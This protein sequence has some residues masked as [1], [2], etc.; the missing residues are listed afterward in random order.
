MTTNTMHIHALCPKCRAAELEAIGQTVGD[1]DLQL[2]TCPS[3]DFV[4]NLAT[5]DPSLLTLRRG[6]STCDECGAQ[7]PDSVPDVVNAYHATSCSLHPSSVS[8]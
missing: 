3:C 8:Q 1:S 7:V 2:L 5:V 4:A 6:C